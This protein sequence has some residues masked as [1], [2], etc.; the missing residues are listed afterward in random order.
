[1]TPA[2]TIAAVVER[3]LCGGPYSRLFACTARTAAKVLPRFRFACSMNRDGQ[4][5]PGASEFVRQSARGLRTARDFIV[6]SARISDQ[7]VK[8]TE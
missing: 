6:P 8:L 3:G 5:G 1:V 2:A 7:P 4:R